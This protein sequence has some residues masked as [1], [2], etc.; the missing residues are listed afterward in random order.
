MGGTLRYAQ[1]LPLQPNPKTRS[2]L[3][4]LLTNHH[5]HQSDRHPVLTIC[6]TSPG[7]IEESVEGLAH[8]ARFEGD[9][10]FEGGVA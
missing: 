10:D 4:Q 9:K 1:S 6:G 5:N 3:D 7:E 8:I 2:F